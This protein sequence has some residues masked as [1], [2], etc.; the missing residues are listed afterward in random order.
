MKKTT[1]KV[2]AERAV[3]AI[4]VYDAAQNNSESFEEEDN[5]GANLAYLMGAI[6]K[7]ETFEAW[8]GVHEEFVTFLRESFGTRHVV[9]S[10]I[11]LMGDSEA[12]P[13]EIQDAMLDAASAHNLKKGDY[14]AA[15]SWVS[16]FLYLTSLDT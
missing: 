12:V 8:P 9:W 4:E 10:S 3:I 2:Q 13:T 14:A 6:L 11:S 5:L 7:G 15:G 16:L 1:Q